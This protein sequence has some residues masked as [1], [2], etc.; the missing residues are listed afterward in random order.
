MEIKVFKFGG[1][2]VNSAEGV[3]NVVTILGKYPGNHIVV[4]V[5]AMAK[6]TNALEELLSCYLSGNTAAAEKQFHRIKE[7]HF[8]T[9]DTLFHEKDHPVFKDLE[10]QFMKLKGIIRP[11]KKISSVNN[12]YN[13]EYDRVVSFGEVFSSL[14]MD[15]YLVSCGIGSKLFDA[16][17][18]ILTDTAHRDAK[19]DWPETS[20]RIRN[21]MM[22]YFGE[23]G[24]RRKV[25]VVQGFI[26][27][28]PSG[29]T[30][31]LG[32][33]GSD[34]SAAIFA[35]A[36]GTK[37]VT[38]WKDVPGVMNADPKW[39]GNARKLDSLSYREA[40]ELAYFGAS[41]IHPKTIKPLEN[42]N[43]TL[44]VKSFLRPELPGTSVKNIKRWKVPFPIYIRKQNQVLISLSPRDF[45][46]ILEENLSDIFNILARHHIR[47]N[48]MQN[49]AISFSFC[50]DE[51]PAL[52]NGCLAALQED[53]LVR[54][55]K[56]LDLFTI[57]HYNQQAID[58]TVKG[59]KVLLEQ[60]TRNTVH[61][62]LR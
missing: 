34:Y 36:L 62:V 23:N 40:I 55:N 31:T 11:R 48:V 20:A 21:V 22:C 4:V 5:S 6:T 7:F 61:L 49:S 54:F 18:L 57:R 35:Y 44:K 12:V 39:F 45:S 51:D 59:R 8:T 32:R 47:V 41:V 53:Y 37:E 3:K 10:Q 28:D 9:V 16:S 15:H 58:K 60:K 19:V 30:T 27:G 13:S 17:K 46:F 38:I 1:A 26:G 43:I 50:V 2:S 29:A 33:E 56:G 14:I 42:A 24:R 25:A 52:E